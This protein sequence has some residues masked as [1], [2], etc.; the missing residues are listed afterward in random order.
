[1]LLPLRLL[2]LQA[3]LQILLHACSANAAATA[4]PAAVGTYV[5]LD[6]SLVNHDTLV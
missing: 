1:M 2:L 6:R 3:L 4:A 5:A